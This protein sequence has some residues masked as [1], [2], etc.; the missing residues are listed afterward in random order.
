MFFPLIYQCYPFVSFRKITVHK[1]CLL[2]ILP[3]SLWH[4]GCPFLCTFRHYSFVVFIFYLCENEGHRCFFSDSTP[5]EISMLYV[6]NAGKKKEDFH[7][8]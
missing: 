3:H 1:Q 6:M 2:S 5:R 7:T 4:L 8:I